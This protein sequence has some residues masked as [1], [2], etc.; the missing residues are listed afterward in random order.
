[1]WD[2]SQF[3]EGVRNTTSLRGRGGIAQGPLHWT[4]NFDEVQDF[5]NQIRDALDKGGRVIHDLPESERSKPKTPNA[6]PKP[7]GGRG[8]GGGGGGLPLHDKF[9]LGFKPTLR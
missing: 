5:E 3:G 9:P 4:G 8:G 2:F 7:G 6:K 1:M